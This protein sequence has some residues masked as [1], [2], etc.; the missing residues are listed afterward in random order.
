MIDDAFDLL[1]YLAF[2]YFGMKNMRAHSKNSLD[3]IIDMDEKL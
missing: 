3:V 2:D 1:D